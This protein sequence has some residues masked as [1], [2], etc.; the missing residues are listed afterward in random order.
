VIDDG[1]IVEENHVENNANLS[2]TEKDPAVVSNISA[3]EKNLITKESQMNFNT[4][5]QHENRLLSAGAN[6][7]NM[8]QRDYS[9]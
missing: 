3:F 7:I 8:F 2:I 5:L 1:V 4:K 6:S 9:N